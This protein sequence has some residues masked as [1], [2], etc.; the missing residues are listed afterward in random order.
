MVKELNA[1][2]WDQEV[3]N[4]KGLVAVEFWYKQC[5]WC[6]RFAPIYEEVSKEYDN[7][8]LASLDILKDE[9]NNEIGQKVGVMGTPTVKVFCG[10]RE[11]GEIVG[12]VPKEELKRQLDHYIKESESC[13]KQSS[14]LS[15]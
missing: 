8:T 3:T 9:A 5:V 12:F 14:D 13:I 1:N 15:K 6:S 4:K 7:I 11:I 2:T 10:G